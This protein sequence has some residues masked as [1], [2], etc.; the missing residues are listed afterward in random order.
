[1]RKDV[2]IIITPDATRT[3]APIL[4]LR[5]LEWIKNHTDFSFIIILGSNGE[6]YDRFTA[7]GKVFIWNEIVSIKNKGI[8]I[9]IISKII[10]KCF[11]TYTLF[12]HRFLKKLKKE[13]HAKRIISNTAVNGNCL[14]MIQEAFNCKTTT[15]VHE[16]YKLLK[17]FNQDALIERNLK[18][19]DE[20][21][22][23]SKF[24]KEILRKNY[25]L[26][27]P[28]HLLGGCID[29]KSKISTQNEQIKTQNNIPKD[30]TIVMCC[31][32][33]TWHKGTDVFIQ[34][35]LQLSKVND[36]IHFVWLGGDFEQIAYKQMLFD[37]E[38]LNLTHKISFVFSVNNSIDYINISDIFL[39]LSREESFSLVT[40]E[41]GLLKKPVLC[42]EN[43]GGPCEITQYDHRFQV[44][45]LDVL[46]LCDR[47]QQLYN[48]PL[49]RKEMGEYLHNI[50]VEKYNINKQAKLLLDILSK[51]NQSAQ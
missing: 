5:Y 34:L 31:G 37:L 25:K 42:F 2:V 45:Y 4:L 20:L 14:T 3:G 38:T 40:I 49:E 23:V 36:Q 51:Y 10:N 19:S 30:K 48:N 1:M 28:I 50:V 39:V 8:F 41:A 35:V 11:P 29:S 18:S 12:G 6:M 46:K 27:Q 9:H 17:S 44:P 43:S 47:I 21:I 26:T 13:Y 16:G 33:L 24:V 32:Y 22:A 15:Y 7:L